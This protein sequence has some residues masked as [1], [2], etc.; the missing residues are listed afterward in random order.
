MLELSL[1]IPIYNEVENIEALTSR[2]ETAMKNR[3]NESW[4]A[5]F[6]DD[7]SVDGS[8][9]L[10]DQAA[11]ARANFRAVRFKANQ[12][13]T[14]AMDA[15]IRRA[16]GEFIA[17]LDADLQNDPQ[18]IGLLMARM[19]DGVDCVC[20]VRVNRQDS[21]LRLA[22]ARIANSVRNWLSDET[23]ADT[24]CSLKLFRAKCFDRVKLYEG[25]H[26]FL[27]TLIKMEGFRVVETPVSHHPRFAGKSKYGVWNRLFKSVVDL[28]AVRW[29]K[30]RRLRYEIIERQEKAT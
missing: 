15:G 2:I 16:R 22:S 21:W 5:I 23:V 4:E 6:V 11:A 29:M 30:K 19:V 26:R 13:Q 18:D 25:M 10:L 1:V 3:S 27:P 12:G 8:D 24:G 28:L 7:G 9:R 17:T 14:A 20:G